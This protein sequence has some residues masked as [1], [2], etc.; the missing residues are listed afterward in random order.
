MP[1]KLPHLTLEAWSKKQDDLKRHLQ[2]K[3][4]KVL[5]PKTLIFAVIYELYTVIAYENTYKKQLIKIA[6]GRHKKNEIINQ[7]NTFEHVCYIFLQN[8]NYE[9]SPKKA[10]FMSCF[11]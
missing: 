1:P 10:I 11:L 2:V 5:H 8:S 7:N 4:R 3:D 9:K 6:L